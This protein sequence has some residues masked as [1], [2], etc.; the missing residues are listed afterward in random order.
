LWLRTNAS[1]LSLLSGRARTPGAWYPVF[2]GASLPT[3]REPLQGD[4]PDQETESVKEVEWKLLRN[5]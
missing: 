1:A 3:R 2:A 4:R 5:A